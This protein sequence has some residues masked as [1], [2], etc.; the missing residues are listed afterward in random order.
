MNF[1]RGTVNILQCVGSKGLPGEETFE[2]KFERSE[3]ERHTK[4]RGKSLGGGGKKVQRPW[5][6]CVFCMPN[7]QWE[8]KSDWNIKYT[9]RKQENMLF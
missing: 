8:G 1:G 3:D 4:L 7:A 2:K 6:N 5:D 9:M